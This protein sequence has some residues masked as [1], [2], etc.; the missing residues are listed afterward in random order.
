VRFIVLLAL[1]LT[2]LHAQTQPKTLD[3]NRHVWVFY[4]GD[5]PVGDGPWGIHFDAQWRRA[6]LGTEWQQYQL[7]PALNFRPSQ[8]VLLTGGYVFT[9]AYPYGDFP[10]ADAIPEH[11]L[12]EQAVVSHKV[13]TLNMQH[14]FRLE[15][16]WL[17]YPNQ[18]SY[19]YQNRYRQMERI[20][21]PL[22]SGWYLPIWDEILLG[23]PPNI[24]ARTFDQNRLFAGI[25]RQMGTLK[26]EGGYMNQFIGQRN[27]RIFE[28][29]S[30][31]VLSIS[32]GLK[33][34]SGGAD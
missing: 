28:F 16:R 10:L 1:L 32:S 24:G 12:Y 26:V 18:T 7:R 14:R 6:D 5:H 34:F 11:R 3:F 4:A 9:K 29:N 22:K 15:Q 8:K 23:I 33:L 27:G 19:T 20:E 31:F 25:G 30:T 17:R 21:I 13:G 2:S